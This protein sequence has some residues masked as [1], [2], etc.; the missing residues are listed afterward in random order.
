MDE[1]D[2]TNTR[3]FGSLVVKN[4]DAR[5]VRFDTIPE[6]D[7]RTDRQTD[8]SAVTIPAL[9]YLAMLLRC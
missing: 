1:P 4:H 8:I 7:G 2:K 3:V 6:C 9:V 5:F